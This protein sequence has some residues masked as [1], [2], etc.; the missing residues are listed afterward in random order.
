M[1][2][3]LAGIFGIFVVFVLT[4]FLKSG[5]WK[6]VEVSEVTVG[7]YNMVFKDFVGPYH[8]IVGTIQEVESW[9][10][11]QGLDCS[12]SFG[13]Y[14][15]DPD[16]VEHERLRSRGGCILAEIPTQLPEGFQSQ[17]MESRLYVMGSFAGSPALGP[18]KVYGHIEDY[19]VNHHLK[20]SA[21]VL[22]IY[23]V[24][25]EKEVETQYLFPVSK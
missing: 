6:S 20:K 25:N 9:A 11:S 14:L 10:K 23:H 24:K 22:E 16:V 13:E 15:D 18:L 2:Q 19:I 7:P 5:A 1:R 3:I 12:S 17:K 21:A 8:K 4:V